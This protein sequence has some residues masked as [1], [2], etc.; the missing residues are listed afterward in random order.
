[1]MRSAF[2]L[3]FLLSTSTTLDRFAAAK[4]PP[5]VDVPTAL[6]DYVS[7]TDDSYGYGVQASEELNGC[8]VHKWELT[9]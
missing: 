3:F 1:M 6:Q 4:E 5:A 8:T 7:T 9:S 2:V